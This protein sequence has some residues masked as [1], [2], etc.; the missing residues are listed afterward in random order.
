MYVDGYLHTHPSNTL[1]RL[2]YPLILTYIHFRFLPSALP[3]LSTL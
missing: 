3:L 2:P 1:L